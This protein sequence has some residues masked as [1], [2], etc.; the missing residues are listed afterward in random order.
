M[1]IAILGTGH[2][3]LITGAT[4]A[5]LGHDVVGTDASAE[6]VAML[7]RGEAPFHEPGLDELLRDGLAD[8]HLAFAD[9][10]AE[11]LEGTEVVFV[12]VG[13]PP[14]GLGDR[15]LTAVEDSAREIARACRERRRPRREVDRAARHHRPHREGRADGTPRARL[16]GRLESRVPARGSCHRGHPAARPAGDRLRRPP[17][18][19]RPP[20]ALRAHARRGRAV[21]RDRPTHRRALQARLERVP[22]HQDLVRERDGPRVR[23]RGRRRRRCHRDHGRGPADRARP[24]CGRASGTAATACRRTS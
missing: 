1:R 3:G 16:R 11:A 20:E 19:R 8:G 2:V 6:K 17:G 7:R 12:C 13:R 21:I 4:L 24:S 18:L 5:R 10:I 9:T 14:V 15:S 23:A 22:R